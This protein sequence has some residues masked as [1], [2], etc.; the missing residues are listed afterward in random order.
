MNLRNTTM[1]RRTTV[2]VK[3][4]KRQIKNTVVVI[5]DGETEEAYFDRLT[6]LNAF[7]NLNFKFVKG[8]EHNY[9]TRKKEYADNPHVLLILDIDNTNPGTSKYGKIESLVKSKTTKK[10]V[11]FNN[12]SFE[13]WLLNHKMYFTKP[14]TDKGQYD[15]HMKNIFSVESWSNNKDETNRTKIMKQL[16]FDDLINAK[17][18]ITKHAKKE[19]HLNPSSNMDEFVAYLQDIKG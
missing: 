18:S 7:P 11:F 1:S 4:S 17:N 13:H 3:Q 16:E 8:N 19:F 14:I 5:G 6:E 2:K 12:Y 10:Y 9:S 15:L